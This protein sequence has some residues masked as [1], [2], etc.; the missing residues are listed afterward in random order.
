M[1]TELNSEAIIENEISA[2]KHGKVIVY[3]TEAVWGI[4]C[5]P[6]DQV[7]VET[8]LKLKNRPVEKG[9]ILVAE[10]VS[11]AAHF[12]DFDAVPIEKR[13]DIF[14]SW[15]GPVTWLLPAKKTC[16][17]WVTGG[18][19]L[20]AI[21][22]SAHPTVRRLC[23]EFGK[24][25]VSTSANVTGTDP[26]MTIDACREVFGENVAFYV[27]EP[28]GGNTRPSEIKHSLTGETLRT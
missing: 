3:P 14:S 24:A 16:P 22:V 26:C 27:D 9:L 19:D 20:V 11:Q 18:S 15:P 12:F 23:K 1:T 5:D 13:A 21:R 4:G 6:D 10:T 28:L 7:A 17:T 2:L 25:I 8:L